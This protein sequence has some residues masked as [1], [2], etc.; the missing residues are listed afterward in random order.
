MNDSTNT[1]NTRPIKSKHV[2]VMTK[3]FA[4]KSLMRNPVAR[5]IKFEISVKM[6]VARPT[7]YLSAM[8]GSKS[9]TNVEVKDVLNI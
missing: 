1:L 2:P 6:F 5:I 9:K 8:I 4:D 7:E 3:A